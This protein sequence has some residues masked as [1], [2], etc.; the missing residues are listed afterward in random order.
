MAMGLVQLRLPLPC[1]TQVA[2]GQRGHC[3][4]GYK[5]SLQEFSVS[6]LSM[7][8]VVDLYLKIRKY[9]LE[10]W[11]G[12]SLPGPKRCLAVIG[13]KCVHLEQKRSPHD[14]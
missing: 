10:I 8:M 12:Q 1:P 9:G 2:A 13:I 14:L 5:P 6:H 3:S 4:N 11:R 7:D